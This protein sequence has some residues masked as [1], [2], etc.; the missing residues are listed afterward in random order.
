MEY[1]FHFLVQQQSQEPAISIRQEC[2][3]LNVIQAIIKFQVSSILTSETLSVDLGAL[4][5][6]T[7]V[8]VFCSVAAM[9]T[10]N[11]QIFTLMY[12]ESI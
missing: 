2:K 4:V 1:L 11:I 6:G 7:S 12:S 5:G 9:G 10:C 3:D 8:S